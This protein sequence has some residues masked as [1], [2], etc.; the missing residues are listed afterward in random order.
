MLFNLALDN[1]GGT[2]ATLMVPGTLVSPTSAA[3]ALKVPTPSACA[4]S[5]L[6]VEFGHSTIDLSRDELDVTTLPCSISKLA[7]RN[8]LPSV[9]PRQVSLLQ[10]AH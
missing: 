2:V 7:A 3:T 4:I 10:P 1:G 9:K 5:K 6:S 8:S